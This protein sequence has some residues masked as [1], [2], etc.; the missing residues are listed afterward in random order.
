MSELTAVGSGAF[1]GCMLTSIELPESTLSIS[2]EAFKNS[3]LL[4]VS[5]PSNL[6]YIYIGAFSENNSLTFIDIPESVE[7]IGNKFFEKCPMLTHIV[8]SGEYTA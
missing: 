1:R 6:Q 8:L 4:N 2:E 3:Q 5:L 7:R